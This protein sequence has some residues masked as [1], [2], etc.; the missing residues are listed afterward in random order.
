LNNKGILQPNKGEIYSNSNICKT[1]NG[2]VDDK[3]S[4]SFHSYN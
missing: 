2:N 3:R 1:K 4:N